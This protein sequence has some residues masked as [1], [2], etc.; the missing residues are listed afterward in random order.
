MQPI[1]QHAIRIYQPY[2]TGRRQQGLSSPANQQAL[3]L[4]FVLHGHPREREGINRLPSLGMANAVPI[5]DAAVSGF[6]KRKDVNVLVRKAVLDCT[7]NTTTSSLFIQY[8]KHYLLLQYSTVKGTVGVILLMIKQSA[9][10]RKIALLVGV[11]NN[12]CT[13]LYSTAKRN[14]NGTKDAIDIMILLFWRCIFKSANLLWAIE[15][16]KY[17]KTAKTDENSPSIS[18]AS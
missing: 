10:Q 6:N 17:F 1:A 2:L 18:I 16:F 13:V 5:T 15:N 3:Y 14:C 4:L 11:Q 9:T 7:N 8:S 12:T